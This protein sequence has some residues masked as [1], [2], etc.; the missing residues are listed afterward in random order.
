MPGRILIKNS[1]QFPNIFI[2]L[3]SIKQQ[4]KGY[5]HDRD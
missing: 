4:E 3:S 2:I 1:L 5:A